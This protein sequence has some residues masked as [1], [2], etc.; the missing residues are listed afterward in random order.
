MR[1]RPPKPY[2]PFDVRGN[3]GRRPRPAPPTAPAA[4]SQT[5]STAPPK[6]MSPAARKI[7]R[8]HI[9]PAIKAGHVHP[10]LDRAIATIFC[11]YGAEVAQLDKLIGES[12]GPDFPSAALVRALRSRDRAAD[13]VLR[14]AGDLGLTPVGRLRLRGRPEPVPP[15]SV[16]DIR[17]RLRT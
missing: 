7:W 8:R 2:E 9:G 6:G 1:G 17:R 5:N 15:G 3:P 4:S 16:E 11:G 13:R 10:L 14:F 12:Q